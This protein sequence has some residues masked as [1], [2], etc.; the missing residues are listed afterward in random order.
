MSLGSTV[1]LYAMVAPQ[2]TGAGVLALM[3]SLAVVHL[4]TAHA[5]RPLFYGARFFEAATIATMVL[6]TA[7][8]LPAYG[9]ADHAA[10]RL[11]L[12]VSILVMAAAVFGLLWRVGAQRFVRFIPA[13]VYIGFAN[14]ITVAIVVT[15]GPA[16]WR[17]AQAFASPGV[18]WLIAA[19]A[20]GVAL[21]SRALRPAW[22]ASGLG[23]LAGVA[24]AALW[25]LQGMSVPTTMVLG[26]W[27]L[28]TLLTDFPAFFA[29]PL[30]FV[31]TAG[32]MVLNAVMIGTLMF[33][34]TV[35]TGQMLTQVD[36]RQDQGRHDAWRQTLAL[37]LAGAS[38]A[39][40][41]SGAPTCSMAAQRHGPIVPAAPLWMAAMAL[42]L[43]LTQSL[44]WIPLVAV[45][46]VMFLDAWVMWDRPSARVAWQWLRGRVPAMHQ[47]EDILLIACVMAAS[48][49]VNMMA[50]LLAGLL[51]GLLLHAV[52]STR[53][54]VR[55]IWTGE[56][57]ASNC[58]RSREEIALLSA[59]GALIRIFQFDSQQFF[60][61]AAQLNRTVREH[62]RGAQYVIM[63]WSQVAH[64]DSSVGVTM[65]RLEAHLRGQG[66]LVWHAGAH[67]H[68]AELP[69]L[70]AQYLHAPEWSTDLDRALE[71]A[72]N[73]LLQEFNPA[74]SSAFADSVEPPW[75]AGLGL[76]QRNAMRR[77]LTEHDFAP[78]DRILTAGDPS[79]EMW[80]IVRGRC[81]V[82]LHHGTAQEMRIAGVSPGTTV[83][84]M[85]FLDGSPRS[86]TVVAETSVHA[87]CM[88]R[89]AFAALGAEAP[90]TVQ[91]IL[92]QLTMDLS[93]RLRHAHAR[94]R[95]Q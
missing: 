25:Q 67:R 92:T 17:Q 68:G 84:E 74:L 6:Q 18:L 1:L 21:L 31:H 94:R 40:P 35:V 85:G 38:G 26:A 69:Q 30:S 78:G 3:L 70:L 23:L 36:E 44:V 52:R 73:L 58:A 34:N 82:Y 33:V 20:L 66:A 59:H 83:G 49:F 16:I 4:F 10:T 76:A 29:A 28:P 53:Q 43:L 50:G 46:A 95:L 89:A 8:L 27:T 64:I 42:L 72:E 11:T 71:R 55:N 65:G 93:A 77:H 63:D 62:S 41:I 51:L 2:H 75:L 79:H 47:R 9:I 61:S 15:Q 57:M 39:A 48:L 22:P 37:L 88:S 24:M 91:Q 80:L 45:S 5:Q 54:P 81:S 14:T 56:Q 12:L 90:G 86:A 60:A 19:V 87:L 13:P 32:L 7:K